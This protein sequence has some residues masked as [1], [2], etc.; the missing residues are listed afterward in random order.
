[1]NKKIFL[2]SLIIVAIST[3]TV[4]CGGGGGGSSKID[5]SKIFKTHCQLCHG[6]DGK[7]G[8]NGAKDLT[9]SELSLDQRIELITN[10]KNTMVPYENILSPEEIKAV[11]QYTMN[12]K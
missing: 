11:A 6:T 10:G 3:L 9:V 7:L 2:G 12:L 4:A 5:A 1:M 8:L